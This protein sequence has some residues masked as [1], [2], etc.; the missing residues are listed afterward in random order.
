MTNYNYVNV[1]TE[2][3]VTTVEIDH[4]P[5]N[6]LSPDSINELRGVFKTL[7]NDPDTRAILLTGAGRFF[8]AGADI[9]KFAE[10]FDDASKAEEISR[11][12][13][14][15]C[16]E[17]E[18]S[19]KP[20]VAAINGAALGG[21]L[22]V[23]MACHYRFASEDAVL[24]LPELKLGLIPS[25]GGT[26]RLRRYLGSARAM[27]FILTSKNMKAN[28]AADLGLV[29]RIVSGE[30][31]RADAHAFAEQLI[32]GK[33]MTS[34][35]RAVEAIMKGIDDSTEN[36][37]AREQQFFGELFCSDDGKE[38]VRAFIDKRTPDFRHS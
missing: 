8:V 32:E 36:S 1:S 13:Q 11:A 2:S 7:S 35:E 10:A 38:G 16:E 6:T 31:V 21:G 30:T 18:Q 23:A 17:I 28:E 4:P 12:G 29:Q 27:E 14:E 37:L 24:G 25:F 20:V 5:A 33:S 9:K 15:L 26:Q 3:F 22:E 19:K 34:I